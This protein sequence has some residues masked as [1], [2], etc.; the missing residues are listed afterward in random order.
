[1][2]IVC[3]QCTFKCV[4]AVMQLTANW[5]INCRLSERHMDTYNYKH[6]NAYTHIY[7]YI[8]IYLYINAHTRIKFVFSYAFFLNM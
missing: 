3:V 2:M 8:Y 5:V 4:T 1:M 7:P 6:I